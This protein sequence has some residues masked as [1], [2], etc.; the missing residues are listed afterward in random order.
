MVVDDLGIHFVGSEAV[1]VGELRGATQA[2]VKHMRSI[3]CMVSIGE[4]WRPGGKT[5]ATAYS[6]KVLKWLRVAFPSFGVLRNAP[7]AT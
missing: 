4:A 2:T 5:F 7:F 3:G 6:I 1:V